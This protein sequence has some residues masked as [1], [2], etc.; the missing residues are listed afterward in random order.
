MT[1][2]IKW[3][4]L[5][6]PHATVGDV[7]GI[8]VPKTPSWVL[9]AQRRQQQRD[10]IRHLG[11]GFDV[12]AGTLVRADGAT[13]PVG[14]ITEATVTDEPTRITGALLVGPVGFLGQRGDHHLTIVTTGP[15]WS[16]PIKHK[17]VERARQLAAE[18][19]TAAHV[20]QR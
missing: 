3:R 8:S 10:D 18:L 17:Y 2:K 6:D 11:V 7:L 9:R 13:L 16:V 1:R 14:T 19:L 5:L 15:V 4:E 20:A 12:E